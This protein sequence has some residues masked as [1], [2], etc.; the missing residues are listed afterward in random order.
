[1][2]AHLLHWP[3]RYPAREPLDAGYE[4]ATDEVDTTAWL[5]L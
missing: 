1:M 2:N 4:L 5:R 3:H